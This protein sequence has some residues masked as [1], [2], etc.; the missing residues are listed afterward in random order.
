MSNTEL[1]LSHKLAIAKLI[2]AKMNLIIDLKIF[3]SVA[4]PDAAMITATNETRAMIAEM[5]EAIDRSSRYTLA[6]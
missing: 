5:T 3:E 6:A 4:N 1:Q 2:E